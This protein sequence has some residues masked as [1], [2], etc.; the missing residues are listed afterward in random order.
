MITRYAPLMTFILRIIIIFIA[1]MAWTYSQAQ[2]PD[3]GLTASTH[4]IV[5]I[6][7]TSNMQY[8]TK[9]IYRTLP[10]VLFD[11]SNP[12]QS[13]LPVYKAN[14]DR[15]S[16]LLAGIRKKK[17]NMPD[18][19]FQ[20]SAA[21]QHFFRPILKLA[22]PGNETDLR[23]LLKKSIKPDCSFKGDYF[24]S[25]LARAN[26]I[27]YLQEQLASTQQDIPN[28]SSFAI[29]I[30]DF[31]TPSYN[32][33]TLLKNGVKEVALALESEKNFYNNYNLRS[34]AS[35]MFTVDK[36]GTLVPLVH[37]TEINK[38]KLKLR[39]HVSS[40]RA[41]EPIK[42]WQRELKKLRGELK[43]LRV[44]I[45]DKENEIVKFAKIQGRLKEELEDSKKNIKKLAQEREE[46][47]IRIRNLN[48]I[49]WILPLVVVLGFIVIILLSPK[50]LSKSRFRGS[51]PEK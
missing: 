50:R 9:T 39:Y 20:F 11:G 22:Q 31:E 15:I 30:V 6:R 10:A 38:K 25:E 18:C 4:F 36:G 33:N 26:V 47:E 45:V 17:K 40:A 44:L 8:L 32:I 28:F 5:V 27:T 2:P 48:I 46:L 23:E 41:V 43:K 21:P 7:D 51:I 34:P 37:S 29:I 1:S 13:G 42:E 35:W 24:S 49:R 16:V 3:D 19:N 14:Q 12:K